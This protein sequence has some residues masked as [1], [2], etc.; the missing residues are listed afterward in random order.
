MNS[1][2]SKNKKLFHLFDGILWENPVLALGLG[3][4][5]AVI[6]TTSM[7]N[8]AVLS[9]A[10][11]CTAVPVFLI[12]SLFAKY[13][14]QW[15]RM[16]VYSLVGAVALIPL[17]LFLSSLFPAVFDSLGVYFALMALNPA[18]LIPALSHRITEEKPGLALLNALCYSAGF[19]LVLFG[20]SLIREPLGSGALWGRPLDMPF[21]LSPIQ[22]SF[23]G[24]IILGYFAAVYQ[25]LERCFIQLAKKRAKN[26]KSSVLEKDS[27]SQDKPKK[28][29][30]EKKEKMAQ[31]E[32]LKK[33]EIAAQNGYNVFEGSSR[34]KLDN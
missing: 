7:K 20:V 33:E 10:M 22:Y 1:S 26:S 21:Q 19:A 24:F 14:P 25:F 31:E 2:T 11:V 3:V 8:A 6:S 9:A 30:K 4:P 28:G 27:V 32:Q 13:I 17:R 23:G 15:L 16:V 5:F 12:A 18:V 29:K 34:N